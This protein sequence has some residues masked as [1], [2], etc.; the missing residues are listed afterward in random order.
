M[1]GDPDMSVG[2]LN[3]I[4]NRDQIER[5]SIEALI[6]RLEKATGPD[7]MLDFDMWVEITKPGGFP[8]LDEPAY[9]RVKWFECWKD[10]SVF[11]NYTASI[12]AALTLKPEGM[13]WRCEDCERKGERWIGAWVAGPD[14]GSSMC[15]A[16]TVWRA[17]TPA[18][19]LC[20]ATLKARSNGRKV[21]TEIVGYFAWEKTVF[22]SVTPAK[23]DLWKEISNFPETK[24]YWEDRTVPG[25][26]VALT[27]KEFRLDLDV[28]A[29]MYPCPPLPKEP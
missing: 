1:I 17:A 25:S 5:A 18:I 3:D 22:S 6:E 29:K 20:I 2:S 11:P 4:D 7:R 13:G 26:K 21:M 19:A 9:T 15:N 8:A 16:P 12:D 24:A 10:R 23:Y 14:A 27:E 28:L